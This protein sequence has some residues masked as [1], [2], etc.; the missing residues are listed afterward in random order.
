MIIIYGLKID[1]IMSEPHYVKF[2]FIQASYLVQ[3][4]LTNNWQFTQI[5]M[6]VFSY[7]CKTELEN[8]ISHLISAMA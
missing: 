6:Y 4:F 7:L 8:G 2:V 1:I 3:L 5:H